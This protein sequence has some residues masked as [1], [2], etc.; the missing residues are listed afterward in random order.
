M[1]KDFEENDDLIFPLVEKFEE[2]LEQ[3]ASYFF[4]VDEFEDIIN[5]YLELQDYKKAGLA[6]QMAM[7]QHPASA[8]FQLKNAQ[9]LASTSKEQSAQIGRAHV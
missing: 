7:K 2:M 9:L 1:N 4:D 8:T 3:R 6:I 5:F